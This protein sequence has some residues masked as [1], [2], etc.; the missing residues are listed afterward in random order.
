MREPMSLNCAGASDTKAQMV[1]CVMTWKVQVTKANSKT[2]TMNTANSDL[3]ERLRHAG[4][5]NALLIGCT[6]SAVPSCI[7]RT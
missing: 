4:A 1:S 6:F 7:R 2:H 5:F 3:G